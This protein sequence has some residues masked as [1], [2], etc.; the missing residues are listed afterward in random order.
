MAQ[1]DYTLW[2]GTLGRELP[3]GTGVVCLDSTPD[4]G[5]AADPACSGAGGMLAVKVFW[6]E[7]GQVARLSVAV[8]P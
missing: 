1:L 2:S 3:T 4:D 8:R 5:S 6:S 7:R